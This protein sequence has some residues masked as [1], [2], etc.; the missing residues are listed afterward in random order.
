MADS[1]LSPDSAPLKPGEVYCVLVEVLHE[2]E[3]SHIEK[4]SANINK[5]C[6]SV[7]CVDIQNVKG[8]TAEELKKVKQIHH[9]MLLENL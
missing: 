6:G 7:F 5:M 2:T 4:M 8:K 3:Q 9:H 1:I